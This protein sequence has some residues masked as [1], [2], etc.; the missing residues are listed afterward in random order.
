MKKDSGNHIY[1]EAR[2]R[3]TNKQGN[4]EGIYT[5]HINGSHFWFELWETMRRKRINEINSR[6]KVIHEW[7][8]YHILEQKGIKQEDHFARYLS[9]LEEVM[10]KWK[11]GGVTIGSKNMVTRLCRWY[12]HNGYR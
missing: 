1:F 5:F 10:G 4:G 12:C 6:I 8:P 11:S 2:G 7:R 9:D 3:S